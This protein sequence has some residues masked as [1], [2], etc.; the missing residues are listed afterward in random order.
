MRKILVVKSR[1]VSSAHCYLR[2]YYSNIVILIIFTKSTADERSK[3]SGCCNAYACSKASTYCH[4]LFSKL[5]VSLTDRSGRPQVMSQ[6]EAGSVN[7]FC[8]FALLNVLLIHT[9]GA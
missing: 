4:I 7:L 2:C 6:R 5:G 1:I 8:V 3:G 9:K